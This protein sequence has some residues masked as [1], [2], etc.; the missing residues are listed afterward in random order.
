[1]IYDRC[2][3]VSLD[4]RQRRRTCWLDLGHE[5]RHA[6]DRGN[7]WED[8]AA[9]LS[10]LRKR[11]GAT[12]QITVTDDGWWKAVAHDHGARHRTEVEPTP[13][14]LVRQLRTRRVPKPLPLL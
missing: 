1:M 13:A 9:I 12:H 5:G 6:D 7:T 14:Q 11:W 4:M 10:R 8:R 3:D 2:G